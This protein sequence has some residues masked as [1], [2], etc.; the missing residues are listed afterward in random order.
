MKANSRELMV[1]L[2]SLMSCEIRVM[3]GWS[4]MVKVWH[5]IMQKQDASLIKDISENQPSDEGDKIAVCLVPRS[6]VK[7]DVQMRAQA[8]QCLRKDLQRQVQSRAREVRP[9]AQP[10][11]SH[12]GHH[13]KTSGHH[14][15]DLRLPLSRSS[16]TESQL[17]RLDYFGRLAVLHGDVELILRWGV[18]VEGGDV[19]LFSALVQMPVP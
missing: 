5:F 15:R 12:V 16:S 17:E 8:L 1:Y 4:M 13:A 11:S 19:N 7:E 2:H 18:D 14:A 10:K 9:A 6:V 3:K